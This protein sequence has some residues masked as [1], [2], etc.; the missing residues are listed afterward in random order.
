MAFDS[1]LPY[2]RRCNKIFSSNN[3]I[4]DI[5]MLDKPFKN[6]DYGR[7]WKPNLS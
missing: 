4:R 6:I 3:V 5:S 1:A 2:R 7:F